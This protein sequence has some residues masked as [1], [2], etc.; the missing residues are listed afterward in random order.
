MLQ[1]DDWLRAENQYRRK[2]GR[3]ITG[4]LAIRRVT[5]PDGTLAY[6][7]G[8][9]EDITERRRV[10]NELRLDEKRLEGLLEIS[11]HAAA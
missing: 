9:V 1:Q 6:L 7:E 5:N 3:L 11:Q 2:D 8:F 10:E 4:N